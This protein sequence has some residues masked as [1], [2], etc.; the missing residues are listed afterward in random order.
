MPLGTIFSCGRQN[1][2]ILARIYTLDDGQPVNALGEIYL[3][4]SPSAM[5]QG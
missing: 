3:A 2:P 4:R 5:W 1:S